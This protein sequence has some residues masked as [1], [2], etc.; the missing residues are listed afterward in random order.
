M[1]HKK[2]CL[3]SWILASKYVTHGHLK[4]LTSL[5]LAFRPILKEDRMD[6]TQ[7]YNPSCPLWVSGQSRIQ[8]STLRSRPTTSAGCTPGPGLT[9]P[10]VKSLKDTLLGIWDKKTPTFLI[11]TSLLLVALPDSESPHMMGVFFT[12]LQARHGDKGIY[13]RWRK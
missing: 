4:F 11:R 10:G 12:T 7:W 8:E 13:F 2:S 1:I 9:P 5:G 3:K 6:C